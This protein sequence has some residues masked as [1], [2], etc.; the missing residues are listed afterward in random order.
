V[1][2]AHHKDYPTEL[3]PGTSHAHAV[4]LVAERP[5]E[6]GLVLDIGC[7]NAPLAGAIADVGHHYVGVDVDRRAVDGLLERGV[8]AHRLDLTRSARTLV[9]QLG[10]I[11]GD[12]ALRAVLAL[13]VLEH[14]VDPRAVVEALATV[15]GRHPGCLLVVSIPNVTH[16]EV[17]IRLLLGQWRMTEFGLLDDTHLRFFSHEGVAELMA[18]TGWRQTGALDTV[19]VRTEQYEVAPGPGAALQAQAPLS[20]FLRSVRAGADPYAETYQFVRRYELAGDDEPRA[21]LPGPVVDGGRA[22]PSTGTFLSAIVRV[23]TDADADGLPQLLADLAGQDPTDQD[24]ADVEVL[25]LVTQGRPS[26]DQV[27]ATASAAARVA[28]LLPVPEG[29]DN[30]NA[31]IARATGRY[32]W[33]L[34]GRTRVAPGAVAAFRRGAPAPDDPLAT[35]AVIRVD[36]ATIPPGDGPVDRTRPFTELVVDAERVDPDGFDLLRPEPAAT[37]LAAYAIPASVARDLGVAVDARVGDAATTELVA[38]AVE[39]AGLRAVG[40]TQVVVDPLDARD[41]ALDAA[42]LRDSLSRRPFLLGRGGVARLV[43]QRGALARAERELARAERELA[44]REAEITRLEAELDDATQERDRAVADVERVLAHPVIRVLS[45]AKRF[46]ERLC[47][48]LRLDRLLGGRLLS[49]R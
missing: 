18:G 42:P 3:E 15:A 39:V 20:R 44:R 25:V 37:A 24:P 6:P 4:A 49:G 38:R 19:A 31:G 16:V 1:S 29:V 28:D 10:E 40:G 43:E 22:V 32:L 11:V 27:A 13:D 12:R 47:R 33:F 35:D 26:A 41:G 9:A 21:S 36:A 48:R 45:R 8:E 5:A 46:V 30:R 17:A 2:A 14:L 7:G 34:D 23:D